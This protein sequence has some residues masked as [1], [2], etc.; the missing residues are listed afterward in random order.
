V[1]AV[2]L[3][4]SSA[5]TALE[6]EPRVSVGQIYTSNV[7]LAPDGEEE[8]DWVT[9][10]AP[11]VNVLLEGTRVRAEVDYELES[12]FY[13]D[14]SDRNEVYHQLDGD[15][16]ADLIGEE[17]QFG[18]RGGI[19]QVSVSPEL[20]ISSSN[21]PVTGNRT[22]AVTWYAGPEWN[23]ELFSNSVA[24]GHMRIG[25][26]LYDD[27]P[28]TDEA[29]PSVDFD[30]Q[31]IDT[32][33]G[34][35]YLRSLEESPRP[36]RYEVAYEYQ[37]VDYE[38]SGELVQ[39]S[40]WLR[41]GYQTTPAWQVFALAGLDSDFE[42]VN[43]DSLDEG[44]WE[45]GVA[46]GTDFARFEAAV[47]HRY[48][49]TTW[50]LA[51]EYV[52]EDINYRLSYQ[53][54]PTTSDLT[55]YRELPTAPPAEG[56]APPPPASSLDRAGAPAL[57]LYKRAD[58]AIS[59]ALYRS[60]ASAGVFWERREDVRAFDRDPTLEVF[61]DDERIYGAFAELGWDLGERTTMGVNASW[62]N[63]EY[64]N[65]I[66]STVPGYDDDLFFLR[67]GLD[68]ELGLRTRAL[69]GTGWSTRDR[70][71]DPGGDYDEYWASVE[72]VRT[73]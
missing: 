25:Q 24:V 58:A 28:R 69:L 20:P 15:L 49:G 70:K 22:D 68:R 62:E 54:T 7:N 11:G 12:L 66:D 38:T 72:L 50:R 71:D 56:A 55:N 34:A 13:A 18:A 53:E 52:D 3:L 17:L 65:T 67:L 44:R 21:I 5:A 23:K 35:F 63:R 27:S 8:S 19:S 29:T 30:I 33:D 46:M 31:D 4:G 43:D 26:V 32:I 39:Q 14:E 36:L 73:F 59:R 51:A 61:L 9:R 1:L 48:F 42:D 40:T 45:T 6:I 57:Y 10:L 41:L 37:S 64:N 60:R 16:L 2:L 47:G